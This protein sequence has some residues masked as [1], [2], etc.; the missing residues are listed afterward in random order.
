MKERLASDQPG[1]PADLTEYPIYQN[2]ADSYY[3]TMKES[4]RESAGI[5][6]ALTR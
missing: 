5:Q 4:L 2:R 1:V 3:A 6:Q